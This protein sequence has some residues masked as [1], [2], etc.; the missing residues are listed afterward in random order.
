MSTFTFRYD[1]GPEIEFEHA[2]V[3]SSIE[4]F[5]KSDDGE[6]TLMHLKSGRVVSSTDSLNTLEARYNSCMLKDIEKR[7]DAG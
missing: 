3:A 2:M 4:R 5:S 1:P 7:I 6:L